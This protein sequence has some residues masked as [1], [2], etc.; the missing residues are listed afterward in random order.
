[1]Q[2]GLRRVI[3]IASRE[4]YADHLAPIAARTT[5]VDA[6]LVAS[7]GDLVKARATGHPRIVL[8][9]HGAG[10]SYSDDHPHYPGGRDNG[11][12]GLFLAPNDHSARR[13]RDAYPDA[14]VEVVGS[15]RLDDL[16]AREPGPLTVAVT[17]H[18]N[19]F[20]T[21]G[22]GMTEGRSAFPWFREALQDVAA[23]FPTIGHGHPKARELPR[24]WKSIGVEYVPTFD[25]VCRRADVLVFDN[26]SAGFEFAATGRPV[27]VMNSPLYRR[28]VSHG[29]RFWDAADVGVQVDHAP[30]LLP[31]IRRALEHRPEDI[32]AREDALESVY[33]FRGGAADRAASVIREWAA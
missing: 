1:M 13:W 28:D 19:S 9:Q 10:Q 8:A 7:Y 29:L 5:D 4:H 2:D 21:P 16:P 18:W 23:A 27:V 11:D 25:E 26:T 32:A 14:A 17:F 15:P 31:A 24:F 6:V 22:K 12:V 20:H 3:V 33:T 30:D